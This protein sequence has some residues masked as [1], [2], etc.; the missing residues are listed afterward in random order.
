MENNQNDS[1][2][3][4]QSGY[5]S[6]ESYVVTPISVQRRYAKAFLSIAISFT[7]ALLLWFAQGSNFDVYTFW[8]M[9]ILAIG[10][11]I[12]IG[13]YQQTELKRP[14]FKFE[15]I[16]LRNR[17]IKSI[18]ISLGTLIFCLFL[19]AVQ[20]HYG[21]LQQYWW[22]V[23][24]IA[25]PGTIWSVIELLIKRK[26]VLTPAGKIATEQLELGRHA[27][28]AER[29]DRWYVRYPMAALMLWGAWMFLENDKSLWMV[30]GATLMAAFLAREISL[31]ILVGM[32][33]YLV[34][35][36]IA[37]LPVSVAVIIGA[38]II[39]SAMRK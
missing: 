6:D 11:W 19:W 15:E 7:L 38:I 37:A 13:Y 14:A 8:P 24:P 21:Q 29:D 20:F 35:Q 5:I 30:V 1:S 27:R 18:S 34:F 31:L 9:L 23:W 36:G 33:I 39:A 4:I 2:K 25:V 12:G 17:L 32:L 10:V 16:P 28:N 3:K 22:Y 26:R